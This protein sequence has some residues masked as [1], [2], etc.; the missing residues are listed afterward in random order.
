MRCLILFGLCLSLVS[1]KGGPAIELCQIDGHATRR[2]ADCA[3]EAIPQGYTRTAESMVDY[4]CLNPTNAEAFFIA[5]RDREPVT[6]DF[7]QIGDGATLDC[8]GLRDGQDFIY[9][10]TWVRAAGYVCTNQRDLRIYLDWCY[11]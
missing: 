7:C 4:V 2:A 6:V 11:R 5:C 9:Q 8:A 10:L 3:T 1:C